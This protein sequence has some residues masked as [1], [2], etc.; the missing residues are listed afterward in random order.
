MTWLIDWW[1]NIDWQ[2][3]ATI[4]TLLL[5]F[6]TCIAVIVSWRT[7]RLY[8]REARL[9]R[10]PHFNLTFAN[11][12]FVE[13]SFLSTDISLTNIGF[14]PAFNIEFVTTQEG[15]VIQP[16]EPNWPSSLGSGEK[17]P[18]SLSWPYG[19]HN[20]GIYFVPEKQNQKIEIKIISLSVDNL[21]LCHIFNFEFI[22]DSRG[23]HSLSTP[24]LKKLKI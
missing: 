3:T 1:M 5:A 24:V 20:N 14:G 15:R 16:S 10:V 22:R 23:N 4:A 19:S 6:F 17:G 7:L 18:F 21:K 2:M 12:H 13:F 8:R 9:R 11:T